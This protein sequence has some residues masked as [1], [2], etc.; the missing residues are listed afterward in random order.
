MRKKKY[1]I[2]L[3]EGLVLGSQVRYYTEQ[4]WK[5]GL[6]DKWE[7]GRGSIIPIGGYKS[8]I[9]RHVSVSDANIEPLEEIGVVRH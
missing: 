7:N 3:P 6:L 9:K 5:L 1:E 2:P 4:G 8:G